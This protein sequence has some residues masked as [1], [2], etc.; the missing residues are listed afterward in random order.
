VRPATADDVPELVRLR[1]L[2]FEAMGRS[3]DGWRQPAAQAFAERIE[4][5]TMRVYVIDGDNG[6]AACAVGLVDRRLPGPGTPNGL[7]GHISGVVTDPAYR[8]GGFARLLTE[9]LLTWFADQDIRRVDL[10]A[11]REAEPLYRALGFF[12][13]PDKALT[14]LAPGRLG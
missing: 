14:W 7:W 10:H 5:G 1:G 9:A 8:R 13:K 3:G 2:M 12:E 4:D 11:S 6:L